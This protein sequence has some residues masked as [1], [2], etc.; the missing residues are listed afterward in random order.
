MDG[1]F[2][3]ELEFQIQ[4]PH[5]EYMII[6]DDTER[7]WCVMKESRYQIV[8]GKKKQWDEFAV[9]ALEYRGQG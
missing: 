2:V 4:I 9:L 6:V 8:N 7:I 3:S 5:A 1:N